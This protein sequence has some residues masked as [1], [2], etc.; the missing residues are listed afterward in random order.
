MKNI[1]S[2][3]RDW[4]RASKLLIEKPA[5]VCK[6]GKGLFYIPTRFLWCFYFLFVNTLYV[7]HC[8]VVTYLFSLADF[9][10]NE[11]RKQFYPVQKHRMFCF[12][13]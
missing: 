11:K 8:R 10:Y 12:A 5:L 3:A 9:V 7:G 4:E 6:V 2:H 13:S 1:R